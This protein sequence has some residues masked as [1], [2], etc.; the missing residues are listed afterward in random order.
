[1]IDD[2]KFDIGMKNFDWKDQVFKALAAFVNLSIED[3]A[4]KIFIEKKILDDME[5][6]LKEF[7]TTDKEEQAVI[8]RVYNF[9]SKL[10]SKNEAAAKIVLKQRHT[11]FKTILY[12][13]SQFKEGDLQINAL[14]TLHPLCRCED[15]KEVCMDTH[16]FTAGVFDQY[17]KEVIKLFQ[18]SQDKSKNADG[19]EDWTSFVNSCAS[20]VAFINSFPERVQEFEPMIKDL[21]RIVKDKTDVVRKNAAILLAKMANDETMNQKI[22]DNHGFDVLMSLRDIFSAKT[23]NDHS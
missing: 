8:F 9:Y 21:I 17:V 2:F 10:L 13:N 5:Q 16:K 14:R 11:V 4:Q 6:L 7:K 12:F 20:T 1:M 18:D 3:S 23:M 15:F 19:K 22:R